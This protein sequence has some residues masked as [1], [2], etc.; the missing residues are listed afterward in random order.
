MRTES[1]MQSTLQMLEKTF[2][3]DVSEGRKLNGHEL[4]KWLQRIEY[5]VFN[6]FFNELDNDS[7]SP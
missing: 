2:D 6:E 5:E 4:E 1:E 3:I 7:P